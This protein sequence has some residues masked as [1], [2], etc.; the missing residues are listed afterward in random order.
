VGDP[1]GSVTFSLAELAVIIEDLMRIADDLL[2][3]G[4]EVNAFLV[5][6]VVNALLHRA[7]GSGR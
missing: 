4:D 2:A 5:D 1:E 7:F 6:Q 3:A